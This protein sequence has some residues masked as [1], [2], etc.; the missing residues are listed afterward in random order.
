MKLVDMSLSPAESK[1]AMGTMLCGPSEPKGP[2]YPYGLSLSLEKVSLDK[3]G[4]AERPAIGTEFTLVAKVKVTGSSE[5][6]TEYEG[7]DKHESKSVS[8]QV[9]E[10][11]LDSG[12]RKATADTFYGG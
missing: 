1:E 12:A 7:G 6:E 3:L 8:L 2:E 11:A 5:S 9:T 10:M 4:I